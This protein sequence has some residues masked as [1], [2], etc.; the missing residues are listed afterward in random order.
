MIET[1]TLQKFFVLFFLIILF[2]ILYHRFEKH[3][4]TKIRNRFRVF[5]QSNTL[6]KQDFRAV[7]RLAIPESLMVSISFFDSTQQEFKGILT[8]LSFSGFAMRPNFPLKKIF[9][10]AVFYNVKLCTPINEIIIASISLIR[11]NHYL[12]RRLIAFHIDKIKEEQFDEL[13]RFTAYLNKF[14]QSND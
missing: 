2:I 13:K 3:R 12:G 9:L 1:E 4:T 14:L 8:N 11:I 10:N 7:P 5:S 6:N